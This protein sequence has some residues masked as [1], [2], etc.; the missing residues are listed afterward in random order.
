MADEPVGDQNQEA[1]PADTPPQTP[2]TVSREEFQT[3]Q[4]SIQQAFEGMNASLQ[5][6]AAARNTQVGTGIPST[7][8]PTIDDIAAEFEAGNHKAGLTKVVGLIKS[9]EEKSTKLLRTQEESHARSL[10]A[11]ARETALNSRDEKGT[12]KMPYFSRYKKEIDA[13]LANAPLDSLKDP[14]CYFAAY[15]LV[16]GQHAT[17]LIEEARQAAIRGTRDKDG[18]ALPGQTGRGAAPGGA[19]LTDLPEGLTQGE[20]SILAS[21]GRTP[22]SYAKSLGYDSTEAWLKAR[23]EAAEVNA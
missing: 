17:E 14:N 1:P 8:E 9:T 22:E 4:S 10:A 13:M 21:M 11:F 20:A 3:L 19:S 5:A 7:P 15:N 2:S 12:S 16:I 18:G 23:K 6:L